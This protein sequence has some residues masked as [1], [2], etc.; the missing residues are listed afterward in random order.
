[1]LPNDVLSA[2]L[3]SAALFQRRSD[4]RS[5]TLYGG[6][7]SAARMIDQHQR[8]TKAVDAGKL[9]LSDRQRVELALPAR[10]MWP[11]TQ[12]CNQPW[13]GGKRHYDA[14]ERLGV[15]MKKDMTI[16]LNGLASDSGPKVWNRI[17]LVA[18]G[19]LDPLLTAPVSVRPSS[20]TGFLAS[21]FV[22]QSLVEDGKLELE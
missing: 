18:E 9:D 17:Q 16:C 10:L 11:W 15:E 12:P 6:A 14:L 2:A 1:M 5:V 20:V 8:V 22:W 7:Q 4:P 13:F 3:P 19:I 21:S